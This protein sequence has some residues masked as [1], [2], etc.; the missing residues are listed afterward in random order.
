MTK[1]ALLIVALTALA[2]PAGL[3]KT[4]QLPN[5]EFAIASITFPKDWA[6]EEI[7]NGVE[8]Q[9]P[10]SAVYLAA[11]AVGNEK[12]MKAEIDDT[13]EFLKKHDVELDQDSKKESKFKL[14][15]EEVQE[16]IFHGKDEDGPCSISISFV[17]MKNK[18]VILTYWVTTA[19]EE[20]HQAEVGKILQSLKPAS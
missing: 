9:S 11:V 8:G 1:I 3:A 17:P 20:E 12:G 15:G 14:N 10:D 7:D 19:K 18:M 5:G 16:L 2:V 13:F 4:F 6:P